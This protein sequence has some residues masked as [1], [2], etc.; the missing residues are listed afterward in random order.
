MKCLHRKMSW[1]EFE[2]FPH[3]LGWKHEYYGGSIHLT[4]SKTAV[5]TFLLELFPRPEP[6]AKGMRPVCSSDEAALVDLFMD[7][8]TDAIEYADYPKTSLRQAASRSVQGFFAAKP[9][10]R[11]SASRLMKRK[12]EVTAAALVVAGRKGPLLQPLFVSRARQRGGIAT[13]LMNAVV[14]ALLAAGETSLY[15]HCHLGNE[16]SMAW[17]ARFGFL[18]LPDAWIAG[19]RYRHYGYELER[20]QRLGDLSVE[21]LA[22]LTQQVDH[23]NA[24][25]RRLTELE[26]QEFHLAHPSLS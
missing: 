8:F 15:S 14:N 10:K 21:Q 3:R 13:A 19:A 17:H 9:D 24:E 25:W 22:T 7:A 5:V 6:D 4:P 16:P 26:R 18:E 20:H 12:G 1:E 2:D 23:W 11:T